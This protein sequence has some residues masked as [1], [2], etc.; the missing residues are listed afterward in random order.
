MTKEQY[1]QI[2]A[3]FRRASHKALSL[4][5]FL[6]KGISGATF[7]SFPILLFMVWIT[8]SFTSAFFYGACAGAAFIFVS[9]FRRIVNRKRPYEAL[10]IDPLIHKKKSGQS[11][12]SRHVFSIFL[13][14][15]LWFPSSHLIGGL[16]LA[17]GVI[18]GAIRVIGGVHY[19]SDVI[20]GAMIGII[21]GLL[22][23]SF[24]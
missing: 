1:Q 16:L 23:V 4:L 11:F 8:S 21:M 22:I 15:V 10:D 9:L 20:C 17:G 7:I 19:L 5:H 24:I 12:P 13:I 14:S 3:P 6:N 2:S 18:L